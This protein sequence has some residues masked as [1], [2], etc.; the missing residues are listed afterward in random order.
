MVVFLRFPVDGMCAAHRW[1]MALAV[2]NSRDD[3]LSA[4]LHFRVKHG[5]GDI[6]EVEP[7]LLDR[8]PEV[9]LV[10]LDF[11]MIVVIAVDELFVRVLFSGWVLLVPDGANNLFDG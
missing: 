7:M 9:L 3:E 11:A 2:E 6:R 1:L 10:F 4:F 8:L 5:L